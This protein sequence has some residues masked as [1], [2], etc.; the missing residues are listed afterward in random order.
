M[1]AP[2]APTHTVDATPVHDRLADG[3]PIV[4]RPLLPADAELLLRGFAKLSP[5]TRYRR[6]LQATD[7]LTPAQVHYLT[8]VDGYDHLAWGA[9]TNDP[10]S[11]E[12][13]GIAVARSVREPVDAH[14][15]EFAIVVADDW[16][17]RGVG[18][19]VTRVLAR[20]ARDAGVQR[21]RATMLATNEAVLKLMALAGQEVSRSMDGRG[22][23]EVVYRLASPEPPA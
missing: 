5:Q 14:E 11:G 8:H 17:G 9:T 6:F 4:I 7:H 10:A 12:T 3:T 20:K 23:L 21:W 18:S 1:P 16:Q 2:P 15:A 22:C 13:I 19:R